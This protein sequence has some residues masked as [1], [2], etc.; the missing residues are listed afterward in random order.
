MLQEL[1]QFFRSTDFV[2]ALVITFGAAVP[3]SLG[4]WLGQVPYFL[5]VAMGVVLASG[6]DVPGSRKHKTVGILVS[7]AIAMLASIAIGLASGSLYLLLPVLA[8]L[9]FAI[10]FISVYGFRAS[11]V[12]FAGLMAIVL[13]FI[14]AHTGADIFI[15]GLLLGTGGLWALLLSLVFHS[16]LQRRQAETL[17]IN[18]LR[19]T[20]RYIYLRGKLTTESPEQ[21]ALQKELYNLQVKLNET[22]E[23]LREVLLHERQSSGTSNYHRKQLLIF[24]ELIDILELS[25]A[26]PANY[27]RARALF[28]QSVRVL[29]P[30][31]KLVFELSAKL[32]DLADSMEQGHALSA[33]KDLEPLLQKCSDSIRAY[34][35][36]LKLPDAREGALLLHNLLDYE[37][38]LLQKISSIERLYLNLE[39]QQSIGL[40]SRESRQFITQQD[41][42]VRILRDS[43]SPKSP[44]F[45]H[46]GRLTIAMLLGYVLGIIFPI[47]NAYWI[48]LTIVV[49]MR[50][51]YTL[52]KERSKHRLYGT[53]LG[54]VIAGLV[55]LLVQNVYLYA[56][57]ALVSLI[58]S[59]AFIQRN[60]RTSSIF[61]TTGVIFIYALITPDAFDAI[62]FRVIDTLTG[63]AIAFGA[64]S[65]LWP[66]WESLSI[67][68]NIV[69]AL[70]ANRSY[71]AEIDRYSQHTSQNTTDYKLARKEAFLQMGNLNAA[72]QR[73]S[74]E[75]KSAQQQLMEIYEI[76]GLNHT[77]LAAAAALGTFIRDNKTEA[78]PED[79]HLIIRSIDANLAQA[80]QTL[81]EEAPQAETV[82]REE[83]VEAYDHLEG[84]YNELVAIRTRELAGATYKPI[85]PGFLKNLKEARLISDQ[86]KWLHT[87]SG[88]LK[89]AVAELV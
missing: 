30:F 48:L 33:E 37:E 32:D 64:I 2:K 83:L 58:L 85:A 79:L 5:S 89:K 1:R 50:P 41:Y 15:H 46:A 77:F 68:G 26:N 67:K 63:A 17:L 25:L 22:H 69:K 56:V 28:G 19:Q 34:V 6:S 39:E 18:C 31:I 43:F 70:H 36:E 35:E 38:K 57:L 62:Q 9:V 61:V 76:V 73:M 59:F 66:S 52:T 80:L 7:A 82:A 16:L 72:F 21:E 51:G 55:V 74:Q 78:A 20:A 71:L 27:E 86:L 45:K 11:L 23:A 47:Q 54:A 13:S 3:V 75:P 44:I 12:S 81:Q 40:Q 53:L 10:S 42:D 87:I 60:Y 29:L 65:F 4:L 24:I 84:R 8:V 88:N 49:I 14:H